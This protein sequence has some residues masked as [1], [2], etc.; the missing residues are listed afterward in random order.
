MSHSVQTQFRTFYPKL[1]YSFF[2]SI[3]FGCKMTVFGIVLGVLHV[4]HGEP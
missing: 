1:I 3:G 4:Q 2:P